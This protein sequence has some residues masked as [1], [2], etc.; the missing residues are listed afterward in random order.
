MNRSIMRIVPL[1]AGASVL[2]MPSDVARAR[3]NKMLVLVTAD[4]GAPPSNRPALL[5]TDHLVREGNTRERAP[6]FG[7]QLIC[8]RCGGS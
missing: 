2:A 3:Q 8:G 1:S 5:G 7:F 4:S 6:P